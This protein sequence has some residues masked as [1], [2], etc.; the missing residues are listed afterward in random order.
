MVGQ[1]GRQ[2]LKTQRFRHG[3]QAEAKTV[4]LVIGLDEQ[5]LQSNGIVDR[6]EHNLQGY[7]ASIPSTPNSV[8]G[9]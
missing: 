4:L 7:S 1:V 6:R 9:Q 8:W 3:R 5:D 2:H